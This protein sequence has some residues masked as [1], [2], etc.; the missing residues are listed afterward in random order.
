[1]HPPPLQNEGDDFSLFPPPPPLFLSF[2]L[3]PSLPLLLLLLP[4]L[5]LANKGHAERRSPPLFTFLRRLPLAFFP[6][7][8]HFFLERCK[9]SETWQQ[10]GKQ[11]DFFLSFAARGCVSVDRGKEA[12]GGLCGVLVGLDG[13]REEEEEEGRGAG[14]GGRE[15]RAERGGEGRGG[16]GGVQG[17]GRGGWCEDCGAVV[18]SASATCLGWHLSPLRWRMLELRVWISPSGVSLSLSLRLPA[19][20]SQAKVA[21]GECCVSPLRRCNS[22][23]GWL[24]GGGVWELVG[25]VCVGGGGGL[26]FFEVKISRLATGFLCV[27]RVLRIVQTRASRICFFFFAAPESAPKRRIFLMFSC[28]HLVLYKRLSCRASSVHGGGAI[29]QPPGLQIQRPAAD[30]LEDSDI[31]VFFSFGGGHGG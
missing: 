4:A 3:S 12:G 31:C 5:G 24:V 19:S 18:G 30:F 14:G 2:F 20:P 13:W 23:V 29:S 10:P 15:R 28:S 26:F 22:G 9:Q 25:G 21:S 16:E 7:L 17:L 11:L 1:M 8:F 6:S 27:R